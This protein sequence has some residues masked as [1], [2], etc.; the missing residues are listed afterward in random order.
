MRPFTQHPD[1][2][3]RNRDGQ[4][5]HHPDSLKPS[6]YTWNTFDLTNPAVAALWQQMCLNLTNTGVIDSCFLDGCV[7]NYHGIAA[8][9]SA[10]LVA[11]KAKMMAELQSQVPGPL[12]CGSTGVV[13]AG[14]VSVLVA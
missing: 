11:S 14:V 3:L 1:Y 9:K 5:L 10:R 2:W 6:N 8:A 4:P 12:L 7:K 13:P